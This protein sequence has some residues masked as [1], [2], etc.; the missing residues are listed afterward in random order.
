MKRSF[1]LRC[2][3]YQWLISLNIVDDAPLGTRIQRHINDCAHCK[4]HYEAERSLNSRLRRDAIKFR[5][6][7]PASLHFRIM[8]AVRQQGRPNLPKQSERIIYKKFAYLTAVAFLLLVCFAIYHPS[9]DSQEESLTVSSKL[10][11]KSVDTVARN[12]DIA[13]GSTALEWTEK[14]EESLDQEMKSLIKDAKSAVTTLAQNF[15]PEHT[16]ITL[17]P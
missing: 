4:T 12:L 13:H 11:E 7:P 17:R 16:R 14:L 3:I 6:D 8:A 2:R 15:L 10:L 5:E 1:N 9:R